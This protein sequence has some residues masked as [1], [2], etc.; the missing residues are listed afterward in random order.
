MS[1]F[2]R[3]VEVDP[4]SK[5]AALAACVADYRS[6]TG[7][8]GVFQVDPSMFRQI[9]NAPFA[10]WVDQPVLSVFASCASVSESGITAEVGASTKDD[11]RFLRCWW[12]VEPNSVLWRPHPKGGA[13]RRVRGAIPMVIK[14]GSDPRELEA[15]VVARYP[16]LRGN[17]SWVLHPGSSYGDPGV[18]WTSRTTAPFSCRALPRRC[19]FGANGLSAF[20]ADREPVRT[21]AALATFNSRPFGY[22]LD[23]QVAAAAGAARSY[24]IGIVGGTP[25]PPLCRETESLLAELALRVWQITLRQDSALQHDHAFVLPAVLQV[26]GGEWDLRLVGIASD[27]VRTTEETTRIWSQIDGIVFDGFGI[28]RAHRGITDGFRS[29]ASPSGQV[30]ELDEEEG[31]HD[32][33]DEAEPTGVDPVDLMEALLEWALGVALGRFDVRLATGER[34]PPPE[35]DP[36]DPLPVCSPGMLQD[37]AGLPVTTA[38]PGY[39]LELPPHGILV[40]DPGHPWDAVAR[41]EA[42]LDLVAGRQAH[43]WV[44]EAEAILE[45]DLR[46]WLRREGFERHLKRYSKSRRKAPLFWHLAPRS[47]EYGI[48]IYSPAATRDT[49]FR[50]LN[51]YV[52]P[53]L[54]AA[55]R[56][57][58]ELRHEAGPAPRGQLRRALAAQETVID[59]LR[60]FQAEVAAVA[61]LWKP[62]RDDGVVLNCAVLWRLFDHHRAWQRECKTKWGDLAKGQY[63]WAGWAMHLWPERVIGVC[64]EDRSIAIAH[65]LEDGL[66]EEDED[67]DEGWKVC[68]DAEEQI[69]TLVEVRSSS[70]LTAALEPFL[71]DR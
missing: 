63:D 47:R 24:E 60:L 18:T 25:F 22:L 44:Q 54:K 6:G 43:A 23:L 67:E 14:W 40:D 17:A 29:L 52:E 46:S 31:Q 61:P 55:E 42:V 50:I 53:K 30:A 71:R 48:W 64:A 39:P 32:E 15:A 27:Q 1:Q 21:L 37:D 12:E 4:S 5:A 35:P 11:F 69:E 51:D 3:L 58:L 34:Q 20:S 8:D 19:I 45:R 68:K 13:F 66:W 9:P 7:C 70:A 57:L 38:P 2:V 28:E 10:Y 33:D 59:E 62:H 56:H 41:I 65:G 26:E 16:Y 36:F 49:F